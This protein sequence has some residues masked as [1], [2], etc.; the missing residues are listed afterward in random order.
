MNERRARPGGLLVLIGFFIFGALVS[1]LTLL[2]LLAPGPWAEPIWQ[3]KPSAEADFRTLG[4]G[5]PPLMLIVSAACAG[6]A[7]GLWR[8]KRWG[9]L[10]LRRNSCG[11]SP[12]RCGKRRIPP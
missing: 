9:L 7:V 2:M 11:Q 6:A 3:L 8:G 5:G 4:A 10:A 1:G 12:G